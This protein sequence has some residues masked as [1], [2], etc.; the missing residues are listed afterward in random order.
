[1]AMGTPLP[2]LDSSA[3]LGFLL[4]VLVAPVCAPLHQLLGSS[5]DSVVHCPTV[6]FAVTGLPCSMGVSY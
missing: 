6:V 3:L 2:A 5:I 1:M 4:D